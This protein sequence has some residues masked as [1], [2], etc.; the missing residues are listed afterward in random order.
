MMRV[1]M[2]AATVLAWDRKI[3]DGQ[4]FASLDLD[5]NRFNEITGN[6]SVFFPK[7]N[8]DVVE[9]LA[10]MK[11]LNARV[12]VRS[13]EHVGSPVNELPDGSGAL[14]L[15]MD[16]FDRTTPVSSRDWSSFDVGAA[17]SIA[18]LAH[19]M[20]AH[21]DVFLPF[22]HNTRQS[23]FSSVFGPHELDKIGLFYRTY[24]KAL[25]RNYATKVQIA[26]ATGTERISRDEFATL[27]SAATVKPVVTSITFEPILIKP[28]KEPW[29]HIWCSPYQKDDFKKLSS[30]IMN[31]KHTFSRSY[32]VIVTVQSGG[33]YS[34]D[35]MCLVMAGDG[36][37]TGALADAE[38]LW[39]DLYKT[40]MEEPNTFA[41]SLSYYRFCKGTAAVTHAIHTTPACWG[42]DQFSDNGFVS[43]IHFSNSDR[44]ADVE[45]DQTFKE[46]LEVVDE[47]VG[48]DDDT[49]E[50]LYG[51]KL[52]SSLQILD[53]TSV[54][55]TLIFFSP[56]D[57]P[58]RNIPNKDFRSRLERHCPVRHYTPSSPIGTGDFFEALPE[59]FASEFRPT[60]TSRGGNELEDFEGKIV[61]KDHTEYNDARK[62]YAT[63]TYKVITALCIFY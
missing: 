31:E 34:F 55:E 17:V 60:T 57:D 11:E 25:M 15:K 43:T 39:P 21:H 14:L 12:M 24:G 36:E 52:F 51:H 2:F 4:I 1:V 54:R 27:S 41:K 45:A 6:F 48:F 32:D 35:E 58:D 33:E 44:L 29:I 18:K 47:G 53:D 3:F 20:E 42:A 56:D 46:Y 8:K 16:A 49:G 23:T 59:G 9:A 37:S 62:S 13:G 40:A 30:S 38:K 5:N 61:D 22:P 19:Q 28:G 63:S 26:T 7:T 10:A 50:Y